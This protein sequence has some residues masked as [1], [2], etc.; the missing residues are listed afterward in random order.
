MFQNLRQGGMIYLLHKNVPSIEMG[1]VVSVGIPTPMYGSN[2]STSGFVPQK[3]VVDVK[4]N[5]G[6]KL[7]DLQKLPADMVIADFGA[8]GMVVSE[9]REAVLSEIE[10]LKTASQKVID[11]IDY[12]NGVIE[13]CSALIEDLNPTAKKE[14]ERNREFDSLKREVSDLRGDMG[15]IK[16]LL[17]KFAKKKD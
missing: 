10:S 16:D 11:S 2:Y 12:H 4:L 9:T 3:M 13:K 6:G 15:E 8:D 1:E 17:A 14:A 7:V 5:V